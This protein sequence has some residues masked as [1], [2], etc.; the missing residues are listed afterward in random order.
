MVEVIA[1]LSNPSMAVELDKLPGAPA[2]ADAAARITRP[3]RQRVRGLTE[4]E[5][6]DLVAA[7][8]AGTPVK[9]LTATF[10]L[11]RDT[12]HDHLRRR[13]IPSR[14][15]PL[16]GVDVDEL[17]QLYEAGWSLER[18]GQRFGVRATSVRYRLLRAGVALRPRNGWQGS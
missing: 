5:I 3:P 7:Y 15:T 4:A 14:E 18:I 2:A 10:H 8:N 1:L 11:H 12:V 6:D 17:A 9:D 13:G 16:A